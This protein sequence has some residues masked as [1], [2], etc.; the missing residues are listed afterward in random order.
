LKGQGAHQKN[1]DVGEAGK[2][3][4]LLGHEGKKREMAEKMVF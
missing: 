1:N 2:R 3:N 4:E